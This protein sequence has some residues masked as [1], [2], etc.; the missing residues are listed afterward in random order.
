METIQNYCAM[1]WN[2]IVFRPI[3]KK[4]SWVDKL[5]SSI[6]FKPEQINGNDKLYNH[7]FMN[8]TIVWFYQKPAQTLWKQNAKSEI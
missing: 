4:G 3:R 1:L 8:N 5:S 6:D 7:P 2:T